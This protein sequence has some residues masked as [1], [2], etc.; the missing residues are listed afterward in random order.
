MAA[1]KQDPCPSLLEC[2]TNE[3][4]TISIQ[5]KELLD[6]NFSRSERSSLM[7][8]GTAIFQGPHTT[9]DL[10]FK[11]LSFSVKV[12]KNEKKTILNNVSGSF[13][14]GELTAVLGPSGA[15]KSSLLNIL[16]GYN[17]NAGEIDGKVLINGSE[18]N[19]RKFRKISCYIMQ[20][21]ILMPNLTVYESMMVSANLHLRAALSHNEKRQV[22]EDILSVLGLSETAHT[23]MNEISGGQR[24]RLA[25]ALELVNNPPIIFLDE[26]TS[27][28]DSL[29]AYQCISLMKTLAQGGRTVVCT[30]H[31]PSAKL[32][33]MFD[34][35]YILTAG[36]CIYQGLLSNLLPYMEK[37]QLV[38]PK[39]HNP[40]DFVIEVASGEFGNNVGDL[41]KAWK[42]Q[43]KREELKMLEAGYDLNEKDVD[44]MLAQQM[45]AA[46]MPGCEIKSNT[47]SLVHTSAVFKTTISTHQK[48]LK[49]FS[50]NRYRTSLSRFG[51]VT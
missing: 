21:D 20:D 46:G 51:D 32:F 11:E 37:Q 10:Q 18:R 7:M 1:K 24:K 30:I 38:C 23:Y 44:A 45:M 47:D 42:I 25:I 50:R 9:V 2:C 17:S 6:P 28:L 8:N 41:V 48:H 49:Y 4:E 26:P 13:K 12:K 33:E 16:A 29:S 5:S 31:Q 43:E 19:L 36:Q 39:Y 3:P 14:S 40:A 15:G 22:I 34:S 35:L 27:G